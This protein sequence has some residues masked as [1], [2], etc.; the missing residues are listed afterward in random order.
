MIYPPIPDEKLLMIPMHKSVEMAESTA[1]PPFKS[2][3]FPISEQIGFSLATA[4]LWYSPKYPEML[5]R[6]PFLNS[7]SIV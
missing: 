5:C 1:F 4:A 7:E 3:S 6:S 2:I